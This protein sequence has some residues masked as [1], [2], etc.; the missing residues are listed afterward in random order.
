MIYHF[1]HKQHRSDCVKAFIRA[2]QQAY[3]LGRFARVQ[4]YS[5]PNQICH[6]HDETVVASAKNLLS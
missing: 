2:T 3:D 5:Q 6:Q 1:S 4:G